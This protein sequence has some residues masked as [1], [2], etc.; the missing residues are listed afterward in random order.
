MLLHNTLY[1]GSENFAQVN[2][3]SDGHS[4]NYRDGL[5]GVLLDVLLVQ[6]FSFFVVLSSI[7][8]TISPQN[9][10]QGNP[11]VLCADERWS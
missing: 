7:K 10:A 11:F 4:A 6:V 2:Q 8:R 1:F 3:T 5:V 9:Y